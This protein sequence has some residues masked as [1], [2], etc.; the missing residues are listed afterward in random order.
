MHAHRAPTR[1]QV[2]CCS[3]ILLPGWV[4]RRTASGALC[5]GDVN[6]GIRTDCS[7][8]GE[9]S[10]GSWQCSHDKTFAEAKAICQAAGARLCAVAELED[11]CTVGTGCGYDQQLIWAERS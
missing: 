5:K 11:G 7:A 3:D 9:S 10:V 8:W 6:C 2:R 1:D 4:P